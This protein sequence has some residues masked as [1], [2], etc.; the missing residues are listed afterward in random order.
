M[1]KK[2]Y[3]VLYACTQTRGVYLDIAT[4]YETE[5][6]LH[7]L[8]RLLASKGNVRLVIS[9]PGSQSRGASKELALWRKDWDQ[10]SLIRFGAEKS[11]D[12]KFVMPSSQH[13]NGAAE[14]LIKM[15]K[16]VKVSMLKALGTQ[17]LTLNE[18]NTL[19]AE[20]SQLVNERPIGLKPN[21][22]THPSYLSPNSL[23]LGRCSDRISSG[24]FES[25]GVFTD[26]PKK[27]SSRFLLVQ[28]ITSQ[29]WKI[30][31]RDFFPSLLIRQKWH[32]KQR[33]VRRNDICLL[34][35]QD[36]FRSEWRLGRVVDVFPDRLGNVRNVEILVKSLQDG[37]RQYVPSAGMRLRRHVNN[38]LVLVPVEDQSNGE[39]QQEEDLA[40]E[41]CEVLGGL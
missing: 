21:E 9:D 12:W 28:A 7:T 31:L 41:T 15:V 14:I 17:V 33:N 3:G 34:R 11:M 22:S 5:A 23:Y 16:G 40:S 20:V 6:V 38:V 36:A 4:S 29:F 26:D 13:Q 39:L 19:L 1:K 32:V 25:D 37:S 27:T 2:V 18:M 35:D 30:W 8:R 10:Q 24:P